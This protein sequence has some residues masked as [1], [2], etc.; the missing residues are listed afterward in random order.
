MI[1]LNNLM[2]GKT[3]FS[4]AQESKPK[5]V[6]IDKDIFIV[7]G[8]T[9]IYKLT[10]NDAALSDTVIDCDCRAGQLNKPCYHAASVVIAKLIE[11]AD[12]RR[13]E[14]EAAAP[15]HVDFDYS[16]IFDLDDHDQMNQADMATLPNT[17]KWNAVKERW[18]ELPREQRATMSFG[19]F[20]GI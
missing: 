20:A 13:A 6:R 19:E 8:H 1:T 15:V 4:K 9:G 12:K 3:A 11:D 16:E 10:I 18:F 5:T 2:N 14:Q 17:P 7:S